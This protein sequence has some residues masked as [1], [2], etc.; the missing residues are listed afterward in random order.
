MPDVLFETM[1]A[2]GLLLLLGLGLLG[3]PACWLIVRACSCSA[4]PPSARSAASIVPAVAFAG[5]C[6]RRRHCTGA[7]PTG[8]AV[9]VVL[10]YMAAAYFVTGHFGLAKK[11]S[12]S[13]VRAAAGAA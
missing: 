4:R 3:G 10:G 13:G 7:G 2:A 8:D 9:V 6:L 12:G 11:W 1:I 5:R